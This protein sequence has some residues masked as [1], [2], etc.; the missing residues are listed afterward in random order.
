MALGSMG[1][2]YLELNEQDKAISQYLAAAEASDNELTAPYT[3]SGQDWFTRCKPIT[4]RHSNFM[5]KLRRTIIP[6]MKVV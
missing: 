6:A 5:N 3:C 4:A 2:A 1:D